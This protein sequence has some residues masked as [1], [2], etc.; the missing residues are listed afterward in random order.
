MLG[1]VLNRL[2]AGDDEEEVVRKQQIDGTKMPEFDAVK[3]VPQPAGFFVI[4]E[5]DGWLV[6]G[7]LLKK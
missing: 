1:K 4:S 3:E 6:T 7:C 5:E 2:A